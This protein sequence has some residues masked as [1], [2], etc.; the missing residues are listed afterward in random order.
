MYGKCGSIYH[1][2][3][4]WGNKTNPFVLWCNEQ[5]NSVGKLSN[6]PSRLPFGA[7][8]V[9]SGANWLVVLGRVLYPLQ[10]PTPPINTF[11]IR[12]TKAHPTAYQGY[13]AKWIAGSPEKSPKIDK[14]KSFEPTK[15]PW[16]WE[17]LHF[18][19][20]IK[21]DRF[22][23]EPNTT[24]WQPWGISHITNG[25]VEGCFCHIMTFIFP[26]HEKRCCC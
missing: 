8:P 19:G 26:G 10:S 5:T 15:P 6:V 25:I 1:T 9:F 12:L 14:G 23:W 22:W 21:W 11:D 18:L 3:I 24:K 13:T 7:R 20:V 16:L 4:L 17:Y 2:W